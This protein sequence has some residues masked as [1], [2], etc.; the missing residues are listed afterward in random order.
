MTVRHTN[1]GIAEIVK[2]AQQ[3]LWLAAD[4]LKKNTSKQQNRRNRIPRTIQHL[5][6]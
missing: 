1:M 5:G 6:R 2:L 4:E 3:N